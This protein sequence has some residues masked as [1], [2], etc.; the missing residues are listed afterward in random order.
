MR[1]QRLLTQVCV[2]L[3]VLWMSCC[4]MIAP[5]ESFASLMHERTLEASRREVL[6]FVR[7]QR[8]PRVRT[9]AQFAEQ[10]IV[11]PTGPYAGRRFRL[12]RQP[13]ARVWFDEIDSGKWQ[14]MAATGPSQSGK[15]LDCYVIPTLYHLFELREDVICGVPKMEMA[16]D[17][18]K[19]DFKPVL[20]ACNL[21]H[22]LPARGKGSRG[23]KFES[24]TFLN[25][26]TLKFMTGGGDDK[27][28]AGYT[29][30]VVVVTE[31]DGM[32]EASEISRESDPISQ[33]EARTRSFGDRKRIY[34]ECTVS[35]E[36]GRIWQEYVNGTASSL[37]LPC[38]HCGEF[39]EPSREHLVGWRGADDALAAGQAARFACPSCGGMWTPEDRVEANKRMRI[40][41]KGQRIENGEVVGELPRTRTLGFR[42]SAVHNLFAT[43]QQLGEEEWESARKVD[44]ESAER[45]RR[46]F[47]WTIP[48]EAAEQAQAKLEVRAI[49][50][51]QSQFGRGEIPPDCRGVTVGID[52]GK[53][54]VHWVAKAWDKD[55]H[56]L[57]L[58]YGIERT[59]ADQLGEEDG[60]KA[61]LS[62]LRDRFAAGWRRPNGQPIY[63]SIALVDSGN[64]TQAIYEWCGQAGPP[65]W[66]SKGIGATNYTTPKAHGKTSSGAA[67]VTVGLDWNLSRQTSGVELVD[68]DADAWKS[69]VH[70]RLECER[71]QQGAVLLFRVDQAEEHFAMARHLTAEL[72][73][74]EFVIGKGV[75]TKWKKQRPDNHWLDCEALAHVGA[76][77]VGLLE[78]DS[79][80]PDA[81][82]TPRSGVN[83]EKRPDGRDWWS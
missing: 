70:S 58:D 65:Y 24:I 6:S 83:V 72:K 68:I 64:W 28:R 45:E 51:R 79:V 3:S 20:E 26:A 41:H 76:D 60:I 80:E 42:W 81:T 15:S 21:R 61:A 63:P 53:Y 44:Q 32:D 71:N 38:R 49:M 34:L 10:E 25:G 48:I 56:G 27:S 4:Q 52:I 62:T 12:D 78:G 5:T 13:W 14:R 69:R 37:V 73:T 17:K 77:C 47:V 39:V 43:E 19:R 33:L 23:G 9:M 46:Q 31:V 50:E 30:R 74:E 54:K 8:A 35:T 55:R 75:V 11:I 66:P 82:P 29:A 67:V 18:W 7:G 40:I 2:I 57:T 59:D 22:Q 1:R 16:E 36:A